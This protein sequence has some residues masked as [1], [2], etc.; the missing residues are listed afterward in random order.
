[1]KTNSCH[2]GYLK[3]FSKTMLKLTISWNFFPKMPS[4]KYLLIH[5]CLFASRKCTELHFF[6][7]RLHAFLHHFCHRGQNHQMVHLPIICEQKGNFV[8]YI[9]IYIYKE[10]KIS[11]SFYIVSYAMMHVRFRTNFVISLQNA[12]VLWYYLLTMYKVG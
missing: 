8:R 9:S 3:S 5:L 7:N 10:I 4:S 2:Q 6:S 1:M 12:S 11:L